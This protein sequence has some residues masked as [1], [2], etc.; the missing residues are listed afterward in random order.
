MFRYFILA[1]TFLFGASNALA[2]TPQD[3][4][5]EAFC[6]GKY[7]EAAQAVD[8]ATRL[9]GTVYSGGSHFRTY[10]TDLIGTVELYRVMQDLPAI[11]NPPASQLW[12]HGFSLSR[13]KPMAS[14]LTRALRLMTWPDPDIKSEDIAKHVILLDVLTSHG[15]S[16]DWWLRIDDFKV[17]EGD[18][19]RFAYRTNRENADYAETHVTETQR[20]IADLIQ[21]HD[22]LD[23]LQAALILSAY[24]HPWRFADGT[25]SPPDLAALFDHIEKKALGGE[26]NRAWLALLSHHKFYNRA[27]PDALSQI[28]RKIAFD[29]ENC[30]A[31]PA[32][33]AALVAG[34]YPLPD[35]AVTPDHLD[36]TLEIEARDVT[37]RTKRTPIFDAQYHAEISALKDRAGDK[38]KYAL[39]LILSAQTSED[40][41]EATQLNP[42]IDRPL[43]FI[44]GKNLENISP[45]AAFTRHISMNRTSDARRVLETALAQRP[46]L[47]SAIADILEDDL[48]QEIKMNM[49]ALRLRCLSHLISNFCTLDELSKMSLKRRDI[50][51]FYVSDK[52][53]QIDLFSWLFPENA[54]WSPSG[55]HLQHSLGEFR[56]SALHNRRRNLQRRHRGIEKNLPY[57]STVRSHTNLSEI[58]PILAEYSPETFEKFKTGQVASSGLFAFAD[59]DEFA[60]ITGERRL[61][62]ALS[63]D[64]IYWVRSAPADPVMAEALHRLV[65]LNKF[66]NGGEVDGK[67]AGQ[68]A[69]EL[70]HQKFPSSDWAKNTPYWWPPRK[71]WR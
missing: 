26:Y 3:K 41:K 51:S 25:P 66:D 28:Q 50:A 48:P 68:V 63:L 69:F 36:L 27:V 16:D 22:E 12:S 45:G 5:L 7:S 23:W 17:G 10:S 34:N 60:A 57:H 70:L 42:S 58:H 9:Y 18:T 2:Q 49:V 71:P 38:R 35:Y 46:E 13:F 15:P 6:D 64:I 67:P 24:D 59:W 61:S 53:I 65:R 43:N 44:S 21:R 11:K 40:I 32:D 62:R 33:Y 1:Y 39:P 29:I 55:Y 30:T 37:F 52:S 19:L 20:V 47:R 31:S 4:P 54:P 56:Y 14:S 8:E